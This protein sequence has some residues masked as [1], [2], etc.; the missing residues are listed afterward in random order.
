MI[1]QRGIIIWICEIGGG[2]VKEGEISLAL[3]NVDDTKL[4]ASSIALTIKI[5]SGV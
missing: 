4:V 2:G 3:R 5:S 1:S